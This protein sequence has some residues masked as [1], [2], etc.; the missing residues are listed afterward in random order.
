MCWDLTA[1]GSNTKFDQA[2]AD[3]AIDFLAYF[4]QNANPTAGARQ[5]TVKDQSPNVSGARANRWLDIFNG[6]IDPWDAQDIVKALV[7]LG[8]NGDSLLN[9]DFTTTYGVLVSSLTKDANGVYKPHGTNI[10]FCGKENL[11]TYS[12]SNTDLAP[13]F[14]PDNAAVGFDK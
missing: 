4:T 11:C 14:L 3:E 6:H 2:F 5:T 12:S 7:H 10:Q 1:L 9:V 13:T 8:A